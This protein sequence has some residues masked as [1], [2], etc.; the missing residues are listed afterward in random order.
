MRINFWVI[1]SY[2]KVKNLSRKSGFEKCKKKQQKS[3]LPKSP[4]GD[5][6][7]RTDIDYNRSL[8]HIVFLNEASY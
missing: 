4:W 1:I 2:L 7:S 3:P 5:K 6:N 8:S